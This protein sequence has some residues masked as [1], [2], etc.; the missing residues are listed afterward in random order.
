[1][2]IKTHIGQTV[3]STSALFHVIKKGDNLCHSK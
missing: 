1:M 3:H 2:N